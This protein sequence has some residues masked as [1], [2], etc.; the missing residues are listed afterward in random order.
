M[1]R[2]SGPD[3]VIVSTENIAAVTKRSLGLNPIKATDFGPDFHVSCNGPLK[4]HTTVCT[5][6]IAPVTKRS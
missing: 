6:T 4:Y 3:E 5:D 1:S 2:E